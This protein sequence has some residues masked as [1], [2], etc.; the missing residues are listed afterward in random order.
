MGQMVS[1]HG[2]IEGGEKSRVSCLAQSLDQPQTAARGALAKVLGPPSSVEMCKN[3]LQ[4]HRGAAMTAPT[5]RH[6]WHHLP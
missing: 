1:H 4:I 3:A 5:D 2:K 6:S